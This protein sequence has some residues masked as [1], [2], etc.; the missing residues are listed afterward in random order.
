MGPNYEAIGFWPNILFT[1]LI[2]FATNVDWG[3]VVYNPSGAS[4]PPMGSSFFP[5]GNSRFDGYCRSITISNE[6]GDSVEVLNITWYTEN[7]YGYKVD[8]KRLLEGRNSFV[9]ALYGGPGV[10]NA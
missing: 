7:I 5:I 9:Y 10:K 8:F 1:D 6:E 4:E 3:G 2:H